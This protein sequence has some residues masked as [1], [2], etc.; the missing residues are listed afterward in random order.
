MLKNCKLNISRKIMSQIHARK[1]VLL[2]IIVLEVKRKIYNPFDYREKSSN[3][4][5]INNLWQNFMGKNI[6]IKQNCKKRRKLKKQKNLIKKLWKNGNSKKIF[7]K[8]KLNLL[9]L[10]LSKLVWKQNQ[11]LINNCLKQ[12]TGLYS[13][14]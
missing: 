6:K 10:I 8:I 7:K 13:I 1:H 4:F 12:A 9:K 14:N 11:N 2:I 3:K 5:S